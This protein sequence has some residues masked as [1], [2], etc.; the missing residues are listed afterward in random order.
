MLLFETVKNFSVHFSTGEV[1]ASNKNTY[2]NGS[3]SILW[4]LPYG[5]VTWD[6][7]VYTIDL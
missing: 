1:V 7:L 5:L 6:G 2:V 3:E 4:C